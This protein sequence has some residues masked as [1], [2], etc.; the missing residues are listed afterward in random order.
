MAKV[1][2]SLGVPAETLEGIVRAYF[3]FLQRTPEFTA[4]ILWENLQGG[5]HLANL[6]EV[7]SKAPILEALREMIDRGIAS[8]QFRPDI[9]RRHML[10]SLFGLCQI[11]FS[12]RHT[13]KLS[14]GLDLDSP[15]ELERGIQHVITLLKAG[16]QCGS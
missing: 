7:L 14:V 13:L 5:V 16:Y 11:Y 4:L 2:R 10:I 1:W 15:A 8:G 6:N 12:N 9:D 3:D